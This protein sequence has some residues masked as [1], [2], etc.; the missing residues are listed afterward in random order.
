MKLLY[1]NKHKLILDINLL[2]KKYLEYL[3]YNKNINIPELLTLSKELRYLLINNFIAFEII[4]DIKQE[5]IINI[6]K[7]DP[8][9]IA[10]MCDLGT[11]K[12]IWIQNQDNPKLK[13]VL[14]NSQIWKVT[15][16]DTKIKFINNTLEINVNNIGNID[17]I[18]VFNMYISNI[19]KDF[20]YGKINILLCRTIKIDKILNR[21]NETIIPK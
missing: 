12:M 4:Y 9:S 16:N 15:E 8:N 20:Y 13:R 10:M 6:I 3:L 17:I 18:K 11:H 19:L 14:F 7:L 21:I 2:E 1:K 5:K